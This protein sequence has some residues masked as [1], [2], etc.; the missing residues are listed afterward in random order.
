MLIDRIIALS[1]LASKD[2]TRRHLCGV[3]LQAHTTKPNTYRLAVTD[4]HKA[5]IENL[6]YN[7]FVDSEA[8]PAGSEWFFSRDDIAM[9]KVIAKAH[10]YPTVEYDV[11]ANLLGI[12]SLIIKPAVARVPPFDQIYTLNNPDNDLTDEKGNTLFNSKSEVVKECTVIGLNAKYLLEIAEALKDG[13]LPVVKLIIKGKTS[14]I[15]VVVGNRD[16]V[17]MPCRV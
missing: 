3:W 12:G 7:P 1:K 13:K 4:G 8:P 5:S 17:L 9:L 14:P 11:E 16:A 6:P 2:E 15:T 10:I